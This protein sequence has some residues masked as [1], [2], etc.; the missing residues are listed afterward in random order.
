LRLHVFTRLTAH[1]CR[2]QGEFPQF[3][4]RQSKLAE[5]AAYVPAIQLHGRPVE[6]VFELV[7]SDENAM[8]Y[9]L[10]WCMAQVRG[11]ISF[12]AAELDSTHPGSDPTVFLQEHGGSSGITDVEVYDPGKV[13]WIFEAKAGF[14]PPSI[15]QLEKYA[16]RLLALDD[17]H[18]AKMLVVL[19]QSDRRDL[20]LKMQ[21]PQS[22][23]GVAVKVMSWGQIR[24]CADRTYSATDNTGK[25]LLRQ[26]TG[27]LDK[28]LGMQVT[29]SNNVFVVS[30]S[31]DTF[32]GGPTTFVEVVEKFGKY[33]HPVGSG[34]PVSP[35]NYMAFRWDGRLQSIHHVDNYEIISDFAPHFPDT[36]EGEMR[37]HF[38]YHL[39]PAIRPGHEVRTGGNIRSARLYAHID[40]LLT[41]N[42]VVEA[43]AKTRE[44]IEQASKG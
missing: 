4:A 3:W 34:W 38:L 40:L 15:E 10:G 5:Y 31:R 11:L 23:S 24:K 12:I 39:G 16:S 17:A 33:F 28:V 41:S 20:W 30:V 44:R 21:V 26:F 22:V 9:A 7:G 36:T 8:T 19:A 14:D 1:W 37:P 27:F 32:G 42:T 29:T 2:T 25:A 43:G 35:P 6:S 13:A 18:A